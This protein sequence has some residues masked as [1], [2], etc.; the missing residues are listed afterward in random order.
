M[1][2]PTRFLLLIACLLPAAC[3]AVHVSSNWNPNVDFAALDTWCFV[4]PASDHPVA[5]SVNQDDFER[6]R[7]AYAIK[8]N[9]ASKGFRE[10]Q[11][12][13]RASFQVSYHQVVNS[14][15]SI[16]KLNDYAGYGDLG[17]DSGIGTGVPMH[18]GGGM[19]EDPFVDHY[20]QDTLF[21]DI[22]TGNGSNLVW[23]GS[24]ASNRARPRGNGTSQDAVDK[25]VDKI[26]ADFPP[27]GGTR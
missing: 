14:E 3:S 16:S 21:I 27:G 17:W 2:I 8:R 9:L 25:R 23:R 19:S 26:L 1:S 5:G 10:V 13:M 20:M 4:T 11:P 6:E 7:V 18:S 22:S 24:G 12:G 15:M